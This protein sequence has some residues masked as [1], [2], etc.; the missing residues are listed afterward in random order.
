MIKNHATGVLYIRNHVVC[1]GSK[2]VPKYQ[3]ET[4]GLSKVSLWMKLGDVSV[5]QRQSNNRWKRE[6]KSGE[7]S[8][9][10]EKTIYV[11]KNLKEREKLSEF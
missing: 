10:H 1:I 11:Y 2:W 7:H 6:R 3:N 5:I 9:V 4:L 8:K